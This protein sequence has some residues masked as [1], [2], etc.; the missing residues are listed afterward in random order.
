MRN[1]VL[2]LEAKIIDSRGNLAP[3]TV[4]TIKSWLTVETIKSWLTVERRTL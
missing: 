2:V 1:G 3:E 4:A